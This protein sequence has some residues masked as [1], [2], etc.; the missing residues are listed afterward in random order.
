MDGLLLGGAPGSLDLA[1]AA[2]L[3]AVLVS[4]GL[5]AAVAVVLAAVA[6]FVVCKL[7]LAK[8]GFIPS[9]LPSSFLCL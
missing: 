5:V 2:V 9:L 7:I 3:L 1:L 4:C 6:V 8:L